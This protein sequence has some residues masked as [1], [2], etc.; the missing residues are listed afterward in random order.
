LVTLLIA[1]LGV[2]LANQGEDRDRRAK[3]RLAMLA[4]FIL[5]TVIGVALWFPAGMGIDMLTERYIGRLQSF[6][7]DQKGLDQLALIVWSESLF[8]IVF[9]TGLGGISFNLMP[10]IDANWALAY[11]PN[12]GLVMVLCDLGLLGLGFI[13]IPLVYLVLRSRNMQ[14]I[15]P[16]PL[17]R[18]AR[19]MGLCLCTLWLVGSG[20]SLGLAVGL[21]L[22]AAAASR[23]GFAEPAMQVSRRIGNLPVRKAAQHDLHVPKVGVV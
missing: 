8:R 5:F 22:L 18:S 11:A 1:L 7:E 15:R 6:T 20:P 19:T 14:R 16:D 4:I 9:G 10:Y 17:R 23:F 12:I 3:R 13:L 21:G 2:R